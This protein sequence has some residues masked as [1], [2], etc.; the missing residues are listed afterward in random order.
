VRLPE[1]EQTAADVQLILTAIRDGG[2]DLVAVRNRTIAIIALDP[3]RSV[4]VLAWL[5]GFAVA[6]L[7][8]L[9]QEGDG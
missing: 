6:A 1:D 5:A 7:D 9:E 8:R 3:V 2:D 4:K